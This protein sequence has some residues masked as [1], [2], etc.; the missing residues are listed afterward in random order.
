MTSPAPGGDSTDGPGT[1]WQ[2]PWVPLRTHR[3]WWRG[4]D[5]T[6]GAQRGRHVWQRPPHPRAP[7]GRISWGVARRGVCGPTAR[8]LRAG[9]ATRDGHARLSRTGRSSPVPDPTRAPRS[10]TAHGWCGDH[11]PAPSP[12]LAARLPRV[13]LLL[14]RRSPRWPRGDRCPGRTLHRRDPLCARSQLAAPHSRSAD[15]G[16][17]QAEG[18]GYPQG[19]LVPTVLEAAGWGA[20]C[21]SPA[22]GVTFHPT[23]VSAP[24]EVSRG[25]VRSPQP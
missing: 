12:A 11:G 20:E 24:A 25:D 16:M 22:L 19:L 2:L 23:G 7:S 14:T 21:P 5:A 17:P 6:T 3:T 15:P 13:F 1:M 4:I 10:G 8:P 9:A 18:P